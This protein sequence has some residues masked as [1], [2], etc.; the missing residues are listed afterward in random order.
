MC[1]RTRDATCPDDWSF[2][3]QEGQIDRGTTEDG[4]VPLEP[5]SVGEANNCNRRPATLAR[6]IERMMALDA[7]LA[8]RALRWLGTER[9]KVQYFRTA[10]TLRPNELPHLGFGAPPRQTVRYFP[11]KLPIGVATDGRTHLFLYLVNRTAPV[12]FRGF[13][14]RHVELFRALAAWEIR[15]LTP[16]HLVNA[17]PERPAAEQAP[18]RVDDECERLCVRTEK[19]R[20]LGVSD[21]LPTG[22]GRS[23]GAA[24]AG[25]LTPRLPPNRR[26]PTAAGSSRGKRRRAESLRQ[27]HVDQTPAMPWR[28]TAAIPQAASSTDRATTCAA[29]T[30]HARSG[31][32]GSLARGNGVDQVRTE[33]CR[34]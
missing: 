30:E 18:C 32:Q 11:D 22:P 19:T 31:V 25:S 20:S 34:Q 8:D 12:D 10:T 27:Q 4:P 16:P 14:H 1:S 13:L 33:R 28:L 7:V 5:Y 26:T 9:E 21:P 2:E 15:L 6:A 23:P 29:R 24:E 3:R 17:A